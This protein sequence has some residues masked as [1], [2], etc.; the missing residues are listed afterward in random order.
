MSDNII[1][2]E[3]DTNVEASTEPSKTEIPSQ[4][5]SA[6]TIDNGQDAGLKITTDKPQDTPKQAYDPSEDFDYSK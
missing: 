6:K 3:V 4:T 2:N 5:A 1:G